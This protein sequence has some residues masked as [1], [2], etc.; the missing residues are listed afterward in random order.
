MLPASWT[1]SG[2]RSVH[3]PGDVVKHIGHRK[4]SRP[5]QKD[6]PPSVEMS[7]ALNSM[8]IYPLFSFKKRLSR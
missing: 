6:A 2:P 5:L 1:A 4:T 7:S 3:R 8:S